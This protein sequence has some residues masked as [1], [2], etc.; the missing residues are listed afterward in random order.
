MPIFDTKRAKQ[1]EDEIEMKHGMLI[2]QYNCIPDNSTV[3]KFH[4]A[5]SLL[6]NVSDELDTI[7]I[8]NYR[9]YWGINKNE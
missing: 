6:R 1:L 5:V 9:K 2:N 8:S 4:Q 7:L 3:D